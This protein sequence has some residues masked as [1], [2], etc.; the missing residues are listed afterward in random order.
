MSDV[1][2]ARSTA[3]SS[4]TAPVPSVPSAASRRRTR[5]ALIVVTAI[6]IVLTPFAVN[7]LFAGALS[8]V[9]QSI[10]SIPAAIV[11]EDQLVTTTNAD[12]TQSVNFA[13]RGLVT[14]LTGSGQ[15]GFDW[16]VTNADDAAAGLA[17]GTYY[18]VLT[19]PSDFSATVNTLGTPDP[20]QGLIDIQTDDAH[21]Y[22]SGVL[23]STVGTAVQAGF[24]QTI[25]ATVV[26]GI[27]TSFGTVGT[28]L[29]DAAAGA[30]QLGSGAGQLADGATQLS[31]GLSQYTSGAS[32]LASGVAQYTD[33][34]TSLSSGVTQYTGGVGQLASGADEL[35]TKTAQLGDFGTGVASYASGVTQL[36]QGL[37]QLSAAA[38]AGLLTPEQVQAQLAGLAAGASQLDANSGALAEAG[39]G[40][41]A[42]QSGIGELASGADQLAA[43]GPALV[44]GAEQ[45]AAG[46]PA[47]SSGADQ[48]AANGPALVQGAQQLGAGAAQLQ[49][50]AGQL[51]SGLTTGA[52]QLG[53]RTSSDPQSA[54]DVIAQPVAVD[55]NTANQVSSVGQVV[56]TVMIPVALW[57]GALAL[58]LWL[59]PFSRSMLASP[60]STGRLV[61][62]TFLRSAVFGVG[63]AVVV[64]AFLHLALG[65]SWSL[66]PA[67]LGFS[68]LVSFAFMAFHQFLTTAFGRMG[69]FVS[70]VLLAL[71]IASTGGLYP[72]QLLSAPFQAINTVSPLA[73][74]VSG[75]QAILAG[76]S[77]STVWTAVAVLLVTLAVGL[78]LAWAVL[79][80][81][82]RPTALGW[83]VPAWSARRPRRV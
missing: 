28:S 14:E 56:S 75:L 60:A 76:G 18:A 51:A 73:Y 42:L 32:T 50:G 1:T 36:T 5:I 11:N 46:G 57:I 23:A 83:V 27:Y 68:L 82:R 6:A 22:L 40:M 4:P 80:R 69:A 16:T 48:L 70:L 63:Q 13:G 52:D 55:V 45:L 7:G 12:G 67:T 9:D 29:K 3:P 41:P 44:S 43:N 66:L 17:D 10:S 24:G 35:R 15:N 58:F 38:Q 31:D 71:Q 81:R 74:A 20:K 54:A 21:G 62:R 26:N 37:S 8:N 19:I 47:L 72:V 79:G 77:A 30:T 25:T 61:G 64:V 2:P 34:V 53:S 49:S 78:L 39:N 59:R 65:A 33:G